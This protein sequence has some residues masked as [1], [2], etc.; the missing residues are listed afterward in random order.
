MQNERNVSCQSAVFKELRLL[1]KLAFNISA[2]LLKRARAFTLCTF[3]I[4][5]PVVDPLPIPHKSHTV[6]RLHWTCKDQPCV[7]DSS[8]RSG[9]IGSTDD[10]PICTQNWNIHSLIFISHF[11]IFFLGVVLHAKLYVNRNVHYIASTVEPS[12][13]TFHCC[14]EV[15]RA[16][17]YL[18]KDHRVPEIALLILQLTGRRPN[19]RLLRVHTL[20]KR[21]R[22]KCSY[23]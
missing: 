20:S 11:P 22:I 13:W 14:L 16:S 21:T 2:Y 8:P 23:T 10:N 12:P 18:M 5:Q 4:K 1:Y 7:W 15:S 6:T 9:A 17:N 19:N 3:C